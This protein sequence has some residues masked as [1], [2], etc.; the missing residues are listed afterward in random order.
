MS[1]FAF[2]RDNLLRP[3]VLKEM[4]TNCM[5][6]ATY[7]AILDQAARIYNYL[8]AKRKRIGKKNMCPYIFDV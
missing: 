8:N 7:T 1:Q 4:Q 5:L 3:V 2:P 6:Y